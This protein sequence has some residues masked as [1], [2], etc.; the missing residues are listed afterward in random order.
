MMMLSVNKDDVI[1]IFLSNL[2]A[3]YFLLYCID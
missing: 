3:F 1:I 2:Y